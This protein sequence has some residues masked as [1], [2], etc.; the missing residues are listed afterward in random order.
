M[1]PKGGLGV[2]LGGSMA[3]GGEYG[4]KKSVET[5]LKKVA[6]ITAIVFLLCAIALP[7]LPS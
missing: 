7:Y 3:G 1:S 5:T 4:S 2:G 6:Y